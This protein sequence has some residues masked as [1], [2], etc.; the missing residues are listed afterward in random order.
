MRKPTANPEHL[1]NKILVAIYVFRSLPAQYI[2]M[3]SSYNPKIKEKARLIILNLLQGGVIKKSLADNGTT[4]FRLTSK[5]YQHVSTEL[6]PQI[7]KPLY[8]YR[9]D[10]GINHVISDHHYYNFVFVWDWISKNTSLLNKNIQIYDDSN[11]NNCFVSFSHDNKKV[12]ISPDILVFQP[13]TKN[14]SFRKATF[15]ENDAG[16][17]TYKRL[18]EK[19]VEYGV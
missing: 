16:G 5:G 10:R 19:F 8:T 9:R 17:E 7:N 4:Y 12:V 13:D 18:Y 15:V 14:S 3:I 1:K 6:M 2:E 11:L